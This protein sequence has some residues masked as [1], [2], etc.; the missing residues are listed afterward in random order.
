MS[1]ED[2][3]SLKICQSCVNQVENVYPIIEFSRNTTKLMSM[4]IGNITLDDLKVRNL[5]LTL[6]YSYKFIF[7]KNKH[8]FFLNSVINIYFKVKLFYFI[9]FV[10]QIMNL[11]KKYC[12][13]QCLINFLEKKIILIF[14]L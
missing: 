7:F 6:R 3:L 5:K 8:F 13:F 11:F 12:I 14:F 10:K 9:I 4:I 2:Q 1:P